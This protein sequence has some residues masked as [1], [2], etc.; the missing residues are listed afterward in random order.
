LPFGHGNGTKNRLAKPV[1]HDKICQIDNVSPNYR[2]LCVCFSP[3]FAAAFAAAAAPQRKH[4][5][6]I[7]I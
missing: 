6:Y 2:F 5:K 3:S 4:F 1:S 7:D